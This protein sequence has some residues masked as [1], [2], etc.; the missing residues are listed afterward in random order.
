MEEK[1]EKIMKE[2]K[3]QEGNLIF[4]LQCLERDFGYL[5]E[6]AIYWFSEKLDIPAAKFF[7]IATFYAQFH[8]KPRGKHII[9]TCC[10]TACHVKGAERLI[11]SL[12]KELG[13]S[14]EEETT[15]DMNFTV[16]KVA[17]LGTCGFAPVVLIDGEVHG[18]VTV[19]TLINKIKK[20]K[21]EL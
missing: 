8:L 5:P 20:L 4:I 18:K 6:K 17:C 16:E 2:Y 13:L 12:R 15:P 3:E 11:N 14:E 7:G 19:E 1:L 21:K 9:T 10:G